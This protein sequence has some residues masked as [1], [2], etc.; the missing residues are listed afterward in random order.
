MKKERLSDRYSKD[1]LKNI[2]TRSS[3]YVAFEMLSMMNNLIAWHNIEMLPKAQKELQES[4]KIFIA[5][6]LKGHQDR[7]LIKSDTTK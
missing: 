6:Q 4:I 3:E 7:A 1:E 2:Q 5:E